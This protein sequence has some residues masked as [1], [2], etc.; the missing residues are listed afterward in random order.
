MREFRKIK[1]DSKGLIIKWDVAI[2]GTED[3]VYEATFKSGQVP[4]SAFL[5]CL[6]ALVVDVP[7]HCELPDDQYKERIR[8]SGISISHNDDGFGVSI[9][10]I[11]T[12]NCGQNMAINGPHLK[13][14]G[15]PHEMITEECKFRVQKLMKEAENVLKD[16]SKQAE[17]FPVA[18]KKAA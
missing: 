5:N 7:V 4:H 12:L 17:L 3:D 10:S 16:V 14:T 1:Y 15:E 8:V 11:I 2:D 9:Q 6:K 13:T 18:K